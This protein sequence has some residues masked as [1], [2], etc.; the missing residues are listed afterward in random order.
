MTDPFETKTEYI[1]RMADEGGGLATQEEVEEHVASSFEQLGTIYVDPENIPSSATIRPA[2]VFTDANDAYRYLEQGGLIVTE[3]D[4]ADVIPIGFVYLLKEYDA[5][6]MEMTWTVY[7]D[8][9][10]NA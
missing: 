8:E 6:L 9:E 2:G 7:I 4:G 5:V 1:V 10:T 3:N